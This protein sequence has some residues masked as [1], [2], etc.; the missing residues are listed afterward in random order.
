M[1]SRSSLHILLPAQAF[2]PRV[3]QLVRSSTI[4]QSARVISTVADRRAKSAIRKLDSP[5]VISKTAPRLAS[6][7]RHFSSTAVA[8]DSTKMAPTDVQQYDYIVLG[9][10]SGGSGSARRAAGWYGAKTLIVESGRSGGTCVNVG[11]VPKKMTWNFASINEALHVG[12]HY[13]YDIPKDIK[14]NYRQFKE[15]RDAVIKRL[16][17]AYERNW[18]KEGIDLVHGRARFVEPKV[19]EVTLNDGGK[20]RYSAPHIL[21][22]TGGRPIIPPVKG[23]EHGITSDGFFEIEELPPK[24]AVVGAGYIAVELAGVMAAV[25]VETHMFIRGETMLRKFD[26]MIQKTMTERYEATGVRIHRKHGGFKEVQLLKDGKG[27]DK[28]LKLIGNDGS[29]EEFNEVLWAIGREPEVGDL[30]LEIPGVKLNEGGHVIVDQYQNTSAEGVYALGDVTGVAEL[31]PVAIAAG[32]QL[33]SRLFGPPALKSAKLSYENIPTVVFAHP[34]VGT[35]GLTEP[36]A[37]QRYGDDK[38]KVYYTK[39]TAMYYDVLPAEE[40][41]KNP[42]EFK[43]VCVGPEEK[44][45]GLHILGLGVGEMLQ[46]FGVAIKMGATKKDFDSCVAIHPTSAEE[47]VTM[48]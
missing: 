26:P 11:C 1:L 23:A 2:K 15:T 39:F 35:I 44:V 34:E 36:Q 21:I 42:T 38:I 19:I 29:E 7:S 46:G 8:A 43:I 22:A 41:K 37:R 13:G 28:V 48:R 25:G 5:T 45:V 18:G 10:G 24:V 4:V 17:G 30:D 9:G 3:P 20:T 47:L 40:K 6:L 14:I 31:T 16:N 12:E 33:G 27:K 32:R